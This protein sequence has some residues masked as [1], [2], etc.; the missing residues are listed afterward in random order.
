V[1]QHRSETPCCGY[2]PSQFHGYRKESHVAVH[3]E[4]IVVAQKSLLVVNF[5]RSTFSKAYVLRFKTYA[6]TRQNLSFC[7]PKHDLLKFK[8]PPFENLLQPI[9]FQSLTISYF[10]PVSFFLYFY[11]KFIVKILRFIRQA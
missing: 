2:H 7:P 10:L 8:M 4:P 11:P 3:V 5:F 1:P 9:Y 6:F